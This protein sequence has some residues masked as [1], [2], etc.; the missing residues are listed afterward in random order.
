MKRLAVRTAAMLVVAAGALGSTPAGAQT[1]GPQTPSCGTFEVDNDETIDGRVFP[2]GTYQLNAFGISCAKV[3]GK[4]GL[5]DQFLSQDDTAPL[6]KP[7][8]SL[9][10]AVGAPKFTAAPGVGFRAERISD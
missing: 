9:T 6:P 8:R 5:F 1:A 2:K 3:R 10:G 4:Y 7:W